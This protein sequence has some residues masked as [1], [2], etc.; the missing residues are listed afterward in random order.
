VLLFVPKMG[1]TTANKQKNSAEQRDYNQRWF[2]YFG[3]LVFS[4]ANFASVVDAKTFQGAGERAFSIA[5]GA[6]STT[7]CALVL[8]FDRVNK[9][10]E[11]FDFKERSDGKLEGYTLLFLV[12]WWVVGTALMTRAD[13]IA[14]KSLNIYFSSWLSLGMS[15]YTLNEW[16]A[17]KDILSFEELTHLSATLKSWY[18]LFLSSLV[19]MGSAAQVHGTLEYRDR[20]DASFA[21]ACGAISW[22]IAMLAILMHY[23]I[24]RWCNIK[25]GGMVELTTCSLLVLFW[26]I[27]VATITQDGGVAATITGTPDC[28]VEGDQSRA[29]GSNLFLSSWTAFLS[30]LSVT[31]R[32]KAAQALRFAQAQETQRRKAEK[33]ASEGSKTEEPDDV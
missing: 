21:V 33:E 16:S 27:G 5:V 17:A 9:L 18:A 8:L 19:T 28:D 2:G 26:M 31:V 15:A 13:G 11:L 24:I 30:S 6:L 12:V 10:A 3:L 22:I 7:V 20:S 29:P 23:K 1:E 25:A 32:W 4:L 14:Y